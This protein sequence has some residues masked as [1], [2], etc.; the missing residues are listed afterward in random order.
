[1]KTTFKK[2]ISILLSL[3]MVFS[4][5]GG[6]GLSA[7][8]AGS[9][10]YYYYS[11]GGEERFQFADYCEVLTEDMTALSG[12]EYGKW[13]VTGYV[14]P[15]GYAGTPAIE[16]SITVTGK[17]NLLL[18]DGYSVWVEGGIY[19]TAGSTLTIYGHNTGKLIC[20]ATDNAAGI[21]G[22]EG[23]VGGN[24]VVN[25]GYV[26]ALGEDGAGIGGGYGENSGF[27]SVTINGGVVT[28]TGDG[29]GAGIGDGE[30]NTKS[31]GSV[32]TINGGTVKA[33]GG[34][35]VEN[36]LSDG[37]G[38]G[39]GGGEDSAHTG[40]SVI[41]NGGT[42]NAQGGDDS[43]GIGGGEN[44]T[45]RRAVTINGGTVN[46]TGGDGG[47]TTGG[48]GAG[49]G[50]GQNGGNGVI[51]INGGTV[52]AKAG[53]L[54]EQ[55][56]E[57]GA[58]IGGGSEGSQDNPI[59]ITGGDVKA[60]GGVCGAG[61]GGGADGEGSDVYISGGTVYAQAGS[62]ADGIGGGKCTKDT[63]PWR[64]VVSIPKPGNTYISGGVVTATTTL[65]PTES[66][67]GAG[68]GCWAGKTNG[69]EVVISG[70][71][72]FASSTGLGAG[73]GGGR[74]MGCS[75]GTIRISDAY[76]VA[77][78]VE[79][80]GIG[81]QGSWSDNH[82]IGGETVEITNSYVFAAS[83]KK[84]AGIGGGNDGDGCP[85]VIKD[86][87]VEAFGGNVDYDW[88]AEH[89]A[90]SAKG[91]AFKLE[92]GKTGYEVNGAVTGMV[93][94]A[95]LTLLNQLTK[96]GNYRGAGIGGGDE[97]EGGDI[98]IE[99][100]S[101][102]AIGGGDQ[103]HGFGH[104]HD[105]NGSNGTLT[106]SDDMMVLAGASEDALA[107]VG[108]NARIDSAWNN[109][110]VKTE[111][112][113]H[114]GAAYAGEPDGHCVEDCPHCA[115]TAEEADLEPHTFGEDKLCAV[116]GYQGVQVAFRSG[117]YGGYAEP[118]VLGRGAQF[119]LP[120]A[121]F[122]ECEDHGYAQ[123]GWLCDGVEYSFGDTITV[124]GD[125]TVTAIYEMYNDVIFV[126]SDHG[127][128]AADKAYAVPGSVVTV[129]ATPD[130]GCRLSGIRMR[131]NGE[132]VYEKN[133]TGAEGLA[134]THSFTMPQSGNVSVY[135]TFNKNYYSVR[136]DVDTFDT[137]I[138]V[139]VN[140]KTA[141]AA[142]YGD[143]ITLRILP[144]DD[145]QGVVWT[146][147]DADGNETGQRH[148]L[149]L[150]A[151][152]SASFTMDV[153]N[154]VLI[155]P[156]RAHEHD[157]VVFRP[158]GD[159]SAEQT[160]LPESGN[161][162]LTHDVV[163]PVSFNPNVGEYHLCLNGHSIT[164]SDDFADAAVFDIYARHFFVHDHDD[165]GVIDARGKCRLFNL[166]NSRLSLFDG[167]LTGGSA[168]TGSVINVSTTND[169]EK[170]CGFTMSGGVVTGNIG[171]SQGIIYT[172][173]AKTTITGG[174]ITGNVA[175]AAV[176]VQKPGVFEISGSPR[177][178]GNHR[179]GSRDGA[180]VLVS[181]DASVSIA[182]KLS[183][184]AI[185]GITANGVPTAA[186]PLTVTNG[187]SGNGEL[188]N[189]FS[190]ERDLRI[191]GV[192]DGEIAI[193]LPVTVSFDANGAAGAPMP[194]DIAGAGCDYTLPPH[195]YSP[196]AGRE[197][198]GWRADDAETI[199]QPDAVV[200]PRADV[201]MH[202]VWNEASGGDV[203]IPEAHVHRWEIRLDDGNPAKATVRCV[204]TTIGGDALCNETEL[205]TVELQTDGRSGAEYARAYNGKAAVTVACKQKAYVWTTAFPEEDL[206]SVSGVS[207]YDETG[208]LL[209]GAP[210]E[211]GVY[212]ARSTVSPV[213]GRGDAVTMSKTIRIVK[214]PAPDVTVKGLE[215]LPL[216]NELQPLVEVGGASAGGK[217]HYRVNG[218]KWTYRLPEASESG[219]YTI[220]WYFDSPN[221]EGIHSEQEPGVVN[222]SISELHEHNG[223][224]FTRWTET[225]SLPTSGSY[226]LAN[227]VVWSKG[228]WTITGEL[229]LCLFGH[230]VRFDRRWTDPDTGVFVNNGGTLNLYGDGAGKLLASSGVEFNV[231]SGGTLNCYD[232]C[233][234]SF[235]G[236]IHVNG[237]FG[238]NGGMVV[239]SSVGVDV[240]NGAFNMNGGVIKNNGFGIKT[241]AGGSINISG[242]A[243]IRDNA[244]FGVSVVRD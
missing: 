149:P 161:Y 179:A 44:S 112:C 89:G 68:I 3:I 141:S 188:K 137:E 76:V 163:L 120:D 146:E 11:A 65:T 110:Y 28:A 8:A 176:T 41:I 64:P 170:Y 26:E 231:S 86:S 168:S 23:A 169:Y 58:G 54:D 121:L 154:D 186:K 207:Y 69:G 237:V 32:I 9:D 51:R 43:A 153:L 49:I 97:G 134:L 222:A 59:Y 194:E 157:G 87:V 67:N 105:T 6:S 48:G 42:V 205:K 79:G 18:R 62:W 187:L 190:D 148:C 72:V 31:G 114:D 119:T 29:G 151:D 224:R 184:K 126:D 15:K 38:A 204:N 133:E 162:Y 35:L 123:T 139:E 4:V 46:A 196:P 192:C 182:G 107:V 198:L 167:T 220:E 203:V 116:C 24:V 164:I 193:A 211:A 236:G 125:I 158:W 5:F 104:G 40:A 53:G 47:I 84:G 208:A 130:T 206:I 135:T 132:T 244:T 214:A 128:A 118:A 12:N 212:T 238:M 216:T 66:E 240:K 92:L 209:S 25:S 173:F 234:D 96:S 61:I 70:G 160:S 33:T 127:S 117:S 185:I 14:S 177:I 174:E 228:P 221:Y 189:F 82:V 73:I 74:T 19:V 100:S 88:Y 80:A 217:M 166:T 122:T 145:I 227:D 129:T 77:T 180:N 138:E 2:S 34:N 71:A 226:Y 155:K 147:T 81:S 85:V 45:D 30:D 223:I 102:L 21:G 218:G 150:G 13:F 197:F 101:V 178:Y 20:K 235:G 219:E 144:N 172:G 109:Y 103:A 60:Y 93:V 210:T 183:E 75:G 50:G 78:S 213:S 229:N 131:A 242:G 225:D 195:T 52:V 115:L 56:D 55:T 230:T 98:T 233:L 142:A 36:R 111:P 113:T 94:S 140:G 215:N 199:L 57:H 63:A 124:N 181:S 202:A 200:S 91:T 10:L 16:H 108:K 243:E 17:V 159:K 1:M 171:S 165:S 22:K 90:V 106:L 99:N 143:E 83:T 37:G 152:S 156:N 241:S 191:A 7:L 175:P 95:V 136:T 39:I 232:A 239:G 27:Q 201:T